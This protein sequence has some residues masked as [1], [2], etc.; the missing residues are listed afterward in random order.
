MSASVSFQPTLPFDEPSASAE[1]TADK[2]AQT[3]QRPRLLEE[4]ARICVERPL[5]EKILVAPTL[6]VGYQIVEALARSGERW[7]NLRVETVRTLA[8]AAI[9]PDLA[10]EGWTLLSRAQSLA[11]VEQACAEALMESSYF[12]SLADRAGLHRSLQAT[13]DELRGAGLSFQTLPETAFADRRK[14][15]ELRDLLRRYVESLEAGRFVDGVEVLRCAAQAV[16]AGKARA[17]EEKTYIVAAE[18]EISALE[19]AFLERLAGGR[20]TF[21]AADPPGAWK[22]LAATARLLRALGEE[23]EIREVFRAILREGVSFDDVEILHTDNTVYPA[24]LWELSR[25]HAIPCTFGGGIPVTYTR[26]GQAALAFLDW[27]GG[28]FE[29]ESLR[30]ALASGALT[31][32]RLD[33]SGSGNRDPV[34][35]PEPEDPGTR[36]A[37]RELRK[38]GIG[39][40]RERHRSCLEGLVAELEKEEYRSHAEA[41]WSDRQQ[42]RRTERRSRRLSAARRAWDFVRRSLALAPET[43][44]GPGDLRSLSRAARS[45]VLD[46]ARVADEL[47]GTARTALDALFEEFGQLLPLRLTTAAAVQRLRDAVA[48]LAIAAD[49]PHPGKVH[50]AFYRAGGFSGRGHT[51]LLGLDEARLPG[52]DL[53]DPVLLDEE[54]RRI[55]ET[56]AEPLLSLGRE[57]PR[58]A[59]AAFWACLGRLRGELTASYSS[60]DLRSL[61]Q[62]GEPAPSPAFL[63]LF[64]A[65]SG[66]PQADYSDLAAAMPRAA[67]FAP[68]EDS[69]LDDAEWWLWRVRGGPGATAGGRGSATAVRAA[70]PWLEDG[71]RAEEARASDEFTAWDGFVRSGTPELDP[72][73]GGEPFSASRVQDLAACPFSY[74][75]RH[76]LGVEAPDDV[77]KDPTRWLDPLGEGSLLHEVF[78]DFFERITAAGEKPQLARHLELILEIAEARIEEWKG[79]VSPRSALAFSVQRENIRFACRTLLALEEEHCREVTPRHFEVPFGLPRQIPSSLSRVSVASPDPVAIEIAPGR[80]FRLRGKI[81]RVDEARDGTFEVWDYK[82]GS[83]LSVREGVGARGG[84]Q[85]QPVLYAM[86]FEMLL[87]RAGLPGKVSRSGYFFPGHK[88]EGQRVIAP[89]DRTETRDV[90]GKLFDLLA[91][92]MFPHALSEDGCRFCDFEA[93]CGGPKEAS[94]RAKRKLESNSNAVLNAFREL[95]AEETS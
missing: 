33:G 2:A 46:F 34:I 50:A 42:A 10:R 67:G 83:R 62:A 64:R 81:D 88:G 68:R 29:A 24:L 26:P 79:R 51:F 8:H 91:A 94:A 93:I 78:R 82:T 7:I 86:A 15:R 22:T 36:A 71:H 66:R 63:D 95:H 20:L 90:L 37:A 44:E 35:P 41:D 57:R 70:C 80:S 39:W 48:R 38:A 60:F 12:G 61:S 11:L 52:R 40:S 16:E 49:R 53:E 84:R 47:D 21:L 25:E 92:G 31:F 74:F 27:I 13:F 55:N 75:V 58:E 32:S 73:A 19:R 14:H 9:G 23:N 30:K 5:E 54:R 17:S 59:A 1:A 69:A 3:T 56:A 43:L 87:E 28:G 77:A 72:R 85:V 89:L 45:F 76:V 4:L 65:Q 6:L 18:T